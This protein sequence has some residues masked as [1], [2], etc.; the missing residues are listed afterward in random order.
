MQELKGTQQKQ[1]VVGKAVSRMMGATGSQGDG[2]VNVVTGQEYGRTP[3]S[4]EAEKAY[5]ATR[6]GRTS[7]DASEYYAVTQGYLRE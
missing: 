3:Y 1:G 6:G 2:S 5:E 7:L 4:G